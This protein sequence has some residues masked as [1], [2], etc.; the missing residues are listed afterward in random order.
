MSQAANAVS[1][2]T[3]T[4]PARLPAKGKQSDRLA[5]TAGADLVDK[6]SD[7]QIL[8]EMVRPVPL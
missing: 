5:A 8:R 4:A 7:A 3:G 2:A 1:T 6:L